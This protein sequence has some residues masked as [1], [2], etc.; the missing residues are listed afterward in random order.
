MVNSIEP[1]AGERQ[2]R[3]KGPGQERRT[4]EWELSTIRNGCTAPAWPDVVLA[5]T[6]RTIS[7]PEEGNR[8]H[9]CALN[10]ALSSFSVNI[11]GQCQARQSEEGECE[12][13]S[14]SFG[15]HLG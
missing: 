9:N 14:R 11:S 13:G 1:V 2:Q 5:F 7:G 12:N 8:A 6:P 3:L 15:R 10:C 4:T